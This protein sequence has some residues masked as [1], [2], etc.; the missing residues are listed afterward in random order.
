MPLAHPPGDAQADFGDSAG[1][2]RW[3]RMQGALPGRRSPAQRRRVC[4][5]RFRPRRRRRS[6]TGTTPRSATSVACRG[7]SSTNNTKLA[8]ARILGDGTRQRTQVFCELQSH[9]FIRRSLRAAGEGQRQRSRWKGWSGTSAANFFVPIPRV[10]QLGRVE[11]RL[12]AQVRRTSRAPV[13]AAHG[14]DRGAL[15]PRLRGAV[16]VTAGPV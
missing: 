15:R 5:R 16:A 13:T 14:D 3:R 12:S 10:R 4:V 2:D 9:V 8:V 7:A 1:R 6:A 11:R